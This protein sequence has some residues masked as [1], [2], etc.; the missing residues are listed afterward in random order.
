[1]DKHWASGQLLVQTV[2]ESAGAILFIQAALAAAVIQ[3]A[4]SQLEHNTQMLLH[5]ALMQVQ[6]MEQRIQ[7]RHSL[8]QL[9]SLKY[10]QNRI[11]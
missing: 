11:Q 9:S 8:A 6:L 1:M 5:L 7:V 4:C 3:I 2:Q 10:F